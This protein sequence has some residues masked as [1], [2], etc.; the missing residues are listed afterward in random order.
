[1]DYK[2][3]ISLWLSFIC[4]LFEIRR[5]VGFTEGMHLFWVVKMSTGTLGKSNILVTE[6]LSVIDYPF[7][8]RALPET[9]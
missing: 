2:I 4:M 3:C 9:K 8:R 5:L 1:M 6:F 7:F